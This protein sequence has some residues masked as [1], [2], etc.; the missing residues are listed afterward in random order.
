MSNTPQTTP[1]AK[2]WR[3]ALALGLS[4]GIGIAVARTLAE[5]LWPGLDHSWYT[6][7]VKHATSILGTV[8]VSGIVGP[9]VLWL[10]RF[11]GRRAPE[12]RHSAQKS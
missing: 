8:L 12:E 6:M 4:I 11:V 7:L 1:P 9:V 3:F 10:F 5:A 2:D